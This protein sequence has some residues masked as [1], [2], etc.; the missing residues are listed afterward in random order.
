MSLSP[1]LYSDPVST[2]S[3]SRFPVVSFPYQYC[4]HIY[5]FFNS[6]HTVAH[7]SIFS[8]LFWH[9]IHF[10]F[11]PVHVVVL[12]TFHLSIISKFSSSLPFSYPLLFIWYPHFLLSHLSSLLTLFHLGIISKFSSSPLSDTSQHPSSSP[13]LTLSIPPLIPPPPPSHPRRAECV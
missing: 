12:S 6:S 13:S 8:P 11:H 4:I 5:L 3:H 9:Y 2:S 1:L 10:Y 7:L